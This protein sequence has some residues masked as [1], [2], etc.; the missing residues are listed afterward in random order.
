MAAFFDG[1]KLD[2]RLRTRYG[3][4]QRRNADQN[5]GRDE[6]QDLTLGGGE[7]QS[8]IRQLETSLC[9]YFGWGTLASG[10]QQATQLEA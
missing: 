6:R 8:H 3:T 2:T 10:G 7:G 4:T 1:C 5:N 9:C